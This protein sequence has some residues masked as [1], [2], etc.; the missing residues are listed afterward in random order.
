VR[1]IVQ[2]S[3]FNK[4]G[5]LGICSKSEPKDSITIALKERAYNVTLTSFL[6]FLLSLVSD[7]T[8]REDLNADVCAMTKLASNLCDEAP[9]LR[10]HLYD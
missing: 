9:V 7:K 1:G 4:T 10:D 6:S 3:T 5:K 8:R 2:S